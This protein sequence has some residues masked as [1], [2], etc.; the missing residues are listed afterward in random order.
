MIRSP[1]LRSQ[2]PQPTSNTPQESDNGPLQAA[3]DAA[4]LM[5]IVSCHKSSITSP[6]VHHKVSLRRGTLSL[7]P[8]LCS[9]GSVSSLDPSCR[10]LY[11]CNLLKKTILK[12][13]HT[14]LTHGFFYTVDFTTKA[15]GDQELSNC[16]AQLWRC[17]A[18]GSI[19]RNGTTL[20][21]VGSMKLML[22]SI[23]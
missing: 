21:H 19:P 1:L 3:R 14:A 18:T 6:P 2:S 11:C 23:T 17:K 10:T 5:L 9:A 8:R 12:N 16:K 4:H 7:T 20:K 13:I 15:C 22:F